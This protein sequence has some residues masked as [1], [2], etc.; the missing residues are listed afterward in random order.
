MIDATA[1]PACDSSQNRF[2]GNKNG[3]RIIVCQNCQTLFTSGDA[4]QQFNY[5]EYYS[6]SN[7]TV[8]DFIN[9]RLNEIVA[10][11]EIYRKNNRFLDVGCGAGSLLAAAK[12]ADWLATGVEVSKPSI[13]FL[14]ERGFQ[15]FH[16]ELEAAHFVENSF[17]VVTASEILEHISQPLALLKESLRILRP[18]GLFWATTPHGRGVSAR[19]LGAD[20]TCVSPPEH[21]QLF[22]V[23]GIKGLLEK[24]GF[25]KVQI[26]AQG[27]NPFEI[28]HSLRGKNV[29]DNRGLDFDTQKSF[30]RVDTSYQLNQALSS[31]SPRKMVKNLL[32]EVLSLTRLGDSLKIWAIK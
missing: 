22:S 3:F 4:G 19:L 16:G 11:F 27:T 2:C 8:P 13:D 17:D 14:Q 5:D 21:L 6:P 32:N 10:G 30:D 15:V 1:C 12:R 18:G 20:W 29:S 25:Q 7:L 23:K 28:I 31:S 26:F 9:Q 24:A